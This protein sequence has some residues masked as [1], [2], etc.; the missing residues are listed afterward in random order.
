MQL[1]AGQMRSGLAGES[2]NIAEIGT[3]ER[4]LAWS[5]V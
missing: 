3:M 2:R 4:T 1:L 5:T